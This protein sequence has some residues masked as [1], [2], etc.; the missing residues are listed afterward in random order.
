MLASLSAA[1]YPLS[2]KSST[3]MTSFQLRASVG[4]TKKTAKW[5]KLGLKHVGS[6]RGSNT[7]DA[8]SNVN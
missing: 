7:L 6:N 2:E 1:R 3:M 4:L 8:E 5:R